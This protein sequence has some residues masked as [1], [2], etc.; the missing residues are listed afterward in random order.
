M[1]LAC[2]SIWS[3]SASV[4]YLMFDHDW[5]EE[6]RSIVR[7]DPRDKGA[8]RGSTFRYAFRMDETMRASEFMWFS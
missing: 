3:R 4:R 1:T 7:G 6:P 2:R 5:S 8:C